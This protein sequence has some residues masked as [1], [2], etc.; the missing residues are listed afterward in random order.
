MLKMSF[1]AIVAVIPLLLVTNATAVDAYP[2]KPIK[3]IVPYTAGGSTDNI[4][5]PLAERPRLEL[6]QPVV[7]ENRP[8]GNNLI[9]AR[10]LLASQPDGY[11]L[12]LATNGLL[13]VAPA[14]YGKLPF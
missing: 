2:T 10:A 5:R 7:V 4:A 14:L 12:M 9:A 13:A 11:T 3:L 6:K 1:A 8:G